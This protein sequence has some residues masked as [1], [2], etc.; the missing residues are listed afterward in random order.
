MKG[1]VLVALL[2][3]LLVN[4][5]PPCYATHVFRT[6]GLGQ[7]DRDNGVLL[8][9]ARDDRTLRIEVGYG[10]EG[11]LTDARSGAIIR[12]EIV[13]R[14]R[15]GNFDGGVLAGVEAIVTSIAGTYVVKASGSSVGGGL[16]GSW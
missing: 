6:W 4:W 14:F 11:D 10:V 12:S 15:A 8:L 2:V 16:S 1:G 7:A 3:A 13:P 5:R 9:I